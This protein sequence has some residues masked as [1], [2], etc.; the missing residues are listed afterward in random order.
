MKFS[1]WFS[2]RLRVGRGADS[3]T[4]TGSAIAVAGV[5]LAL[6]IMELSLA[7]SAGF[8]HEIERK[9]LGFDAAIA[10]LPA[11]DFNTG[12]T[13]SEMTP[14]A[15][16]S[17]VISEVLPASR[18]VEAF[19][20][21]AILKTDSN[22]LAVECLAYGPSHDNS[23]EQG[24][25]VRG[26]FTAS[27]D[28]IVISSFMARNLG[29]DTAHRVFL[30]FFVDG[31]PKARRL[32]VSGIYNSNF[33]D[34]DRSI[35]YTS[36]PL[37]QGLGENPSSVSALNIEGLSGTDVDSIIDRS[38]RLQQAII[39][40]YAR[41]RLAEVHSVTNVVEQGAVFFSWLGLL[42]T[43]VVVI[44]IL[45]ACVAAF[46]L[47]SSLFIIILDRIPTIGILRSLGASKAVVSR[48][49][50]NIAL[51]LVGLGMI[52]GNILALSV[53][54]IQKATGFLPLDPEMYYLDKVPFEISWL[55]V[56]LLNVGVILGAWLIL[57]LPSRIA[58]RI[59]PSAT[60]RYE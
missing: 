45:M 47:I 52:I 17:D 18:Q 38:R 6:M 28:S 35:L 29:I 60:M 9:L 7:V 57:I 44:F 16:L 39:D 2:K 30:Y 14:S 13:A 20:R 4:T 53:I 10:V 56:L 5:A 27:D 43:N 36:L 25:L 34:Y 37:L 58:A 42:D 54:F 51:R 55:A 22:F 41:G 59:D 26:R 31:T 12:R 33:S 49:F 50:L 15:E 3:S 48:I 1:F 23:F 11:Y 21:H 19:R 24:N 40:N 32:F 8:K 46:T